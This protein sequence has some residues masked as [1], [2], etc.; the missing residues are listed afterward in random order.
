[1]DRR[2]KRI[3]FYTRKVAELVSIH[4][5]KRDTRWKIRQQRLL[6]YKKKMNQWLKE[7]EASGKE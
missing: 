1:M 2:V 7:H 5:T 3:E 4:P 6:N